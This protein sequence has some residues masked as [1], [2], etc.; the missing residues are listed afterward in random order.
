MAT[1]RSVPKAE[2]REFFDRFSKGLLGKWAEIEVA[3][4]DLGAQV[5][6]DWLPLIGIV[7]DPK[8]DRWEKPK[9]VKISD[10]CK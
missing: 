1:F 6:A 3:G 7:Y 10:T 4:L 2:W 5:E 9:G 8:D